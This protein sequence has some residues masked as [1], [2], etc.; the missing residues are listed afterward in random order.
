[1]TPVMYKVFRLGCL[2]SHSKSVIMQA[3][4][5][6]YS[7][8]KPRFPHRDRGCTKGVVRIH[9]TY[10]AFFLCSKRKEKNEQIRA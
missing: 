1:M 2:F 9:L 7:S 6:S 3:H 5:K 4:R 8:D 10:Y